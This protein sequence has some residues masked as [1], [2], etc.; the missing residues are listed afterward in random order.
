MRDAA[1]L[2][3]LLERGDAELVLYGHNHKTR[4]D[5]LP[6]R[7]KAVPLVGVASASASVAHG[8]EPLASYNLFTFFKSENGLRIRHTVRGIDAPET[9]VKK[10][11][12]TIL[13]AT[14]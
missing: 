3:H 1:H 10:I 6:S 2:A 12:E 7:K 4:V 8:E 13:T 5:W 14:T 9:P 11:S